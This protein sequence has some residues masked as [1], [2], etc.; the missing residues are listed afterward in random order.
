MNTTNKDFITI[1]EEYRQKHYPKGFFEAM[2]KNGGGVF[3]IILGL[4]LAI[5]GLLFGFL[6]VI[7]LITN[8]QSENIG[9]DTSVII[10]F[11]VIAMVLFVVT[12]L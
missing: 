12:V 4:V 5:I 11:S 10:F 1:S 3:F 7:L 9:D 6:A 8:L 2:G